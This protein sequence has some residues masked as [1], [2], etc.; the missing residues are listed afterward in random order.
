MAIESEKFQAVPKF[1]F[2]WILAIVSFATALRFF[3][4]G[5]ESLWNDELSTWLRAVDGDLAD[6][7]S[8]LKNDPH[9]P[10]FFVI[11]R[12]VGQTLGDSEALLRLPS[13]LGGVLAVILVWVFGRKFFNPN[14]G[15]IAAAFIAVAWTPIY[16][17]QEAR[18]YSMLMASAIF[19]MYF[20]LSFFVGDKFSGAKVDKI[21]FLFFALS[22]LV[23]SYLH[24]FG[25]MFSGLIVLGLI[26]GAIFDSSKR[27]LAI[28]SVVAFAFIVS[29]WS[30]IMLHQFSG[31]AGTWIRFSSLS[32]M[33]Y[34]QS[35]F[36]FT[37]SPNLRN[38]FL[39][40]LGLFVVDIAF[41]LFGRPG[42]IRRNVDLKRDIAIVS[43]VVVPLLVSYLLGLF[44]KPLW[45]PRNLIVILPAAFIMVA[46]VAVDFR[47]KRLGTL[48]GVVLVALLAYDTLE[49][50]NYFD[51]V[52]K[53]QFREAAEFACRDYNGEPI[54]VFTW[55]SA[56]FGYY[57]RDFCGEFS[58][59]GRFGRSQDLGEI[60]QLVQELGVNRFWYLT[61]HRRAETSFIQGMSETYVLEQ[62]KILRGATARL[63]SVP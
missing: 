10:L 53:Q 16:Y 54:F 47:L 27:K 42:L 61:G 32:E 46:S 36:S 5:E 2:F 55:S 7:I 62:E 34:E 26:A 25:M 9:P 29:A 35:R 15:L 45:T 11:I 31:D 30:P 19:A 1:E 18:A 13:A 22:I 58:I 48:L 38:A 4:L 40:L 63:Y 56:Q 49:T 39:V 50:R 43:W 20:G 44:L 12:A 21:K 24:Y 41:C 57:L 33:T 51:R 17:S 6:L 52:K 28:L 37:T 3:E 23:M 14:V 8:F 60:V 59:Y